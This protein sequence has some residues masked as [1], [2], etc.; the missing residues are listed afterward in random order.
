MATY[1]S[2]H[3]IFESQSLLPLLLRNCSSDIGETWDMITFNPGCVYDIWGPLEKQNGR[4][5][6]ILD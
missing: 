1:C 4:Q 2:G 3:L 5:V 6:A